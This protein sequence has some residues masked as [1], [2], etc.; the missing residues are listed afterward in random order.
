MLRTL[1]YV[2]AV[3]GKG[4]CYIFV[5]SLTRSFNLFIIYGLRFGKF[6][7][8]VKGIKLRNVW[9]EE[10]EVG[11]DGVRACMGLGSNY[12]TALIK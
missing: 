12:V 7:A 2:D 5:F 3:I 10:M 6:V 1:A 9:G 8:S 11:L 4:T